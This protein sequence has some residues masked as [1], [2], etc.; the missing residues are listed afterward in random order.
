MTIIL[1]CGHEV[2][3][4]DRAFYVRTKSTD[5]EGNKAIRLSLMCGACEDQYRQA[6]EV[7]ESDDAADAWLEKESW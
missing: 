5:R 4:Y 3:S 7:L 1:S 2:D 6:G